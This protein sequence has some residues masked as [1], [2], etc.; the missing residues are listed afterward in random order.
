MRINITL[1]NFSGL[2]IGTE[3]FL[4]SKIFNNAGKAQGKQGF[5]ILKFKINRTV[6][7]SFSVPVSLSSIGTVSPTSSSKT[8]N[9]LLSAMKMGGSMNMTGMHRI[10]GKTYDKSRIDE[11]VAANTTEIWVFDNSQGDEPH[12]MHMHG[13]HFQVWERSGGRGQLIPSES[14]WKDTV[15]VLPGEIVKILI[16]FSTLTGVFVFHC[17]NLEH[18]DDGMMLQYKL[19]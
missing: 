7:D 8:R 1:V 13:V 19:T 4:E 10:N 14:G 3:V 15:L 5:K 16:P 17:H 9:F 6:S 18:E 11:T 2:T 12:P